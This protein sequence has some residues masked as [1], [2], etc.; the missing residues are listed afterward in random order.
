MQEQLD[1]LGEVQVLKCNFT[2]F[3]RVLTGAVQPTL[4]DSC[5]PLT[6]LYYWLYKTWF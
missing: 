6:V 1:R 3:K 4:L 2:L 5:M